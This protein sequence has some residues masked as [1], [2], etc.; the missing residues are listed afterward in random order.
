MEEIVV[1]EKALIDNENSLLSNFD[2]EKDSTGRTGFNPAII[3]M[4][5]EGGENFFRYLKKLN[6]SRESNI[7]VLP[8]DHH[9]YYEETELQ[10]VKTLVILKKLN[11]IK[12]PDRYLHNLFRILP[13]NANVIGCFS[14]DKTH[15]KNGF[16]NYM[17]SRLFNRFINFLDS[18]TD[19]IMSKN[20]VKELLES[21]GF[22]V[23]D[24]TMMNGLTYFYSRNLRQIELRA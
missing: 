8:S 19:H 15:N 16:S 21:H 4:I 17:S 11:Y 7:L 14:D 1:L 10:N 5:S 18:K 23:V 9:Y 2:R 3:K 24:M 12:R 13:P 6:L 22:K 20:E